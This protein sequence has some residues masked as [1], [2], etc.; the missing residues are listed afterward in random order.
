MND[1][2]SRT[3]LVVVIV[4]AVHH[5]VFLLIYKEKFIDLNLILRYLAVSSFASIYL[6]MVQGLVFSD[7]E[8]HHIRV[9]L[10]YLLF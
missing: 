5:M 4:V 8:C 6:A 9:F 3:T 1:C 10:K 7:G 2:N